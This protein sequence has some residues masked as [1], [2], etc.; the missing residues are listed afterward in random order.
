MGVTTESSLEGRPSRQG[1]PALQN[2]PG[3]Y[4]K[5]YKCLSLYWQGSEKGIAWGLLIGSILLTLTIVACQAFLTFW[6]KEF[7]NALQ[8]YDVREFWRLMLWFGLL[9]F[10]LIICAISKNY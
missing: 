4:S 5:L 9:A 8:N 1:P 2:Y 6:Y 7:Y 10:F 3:F